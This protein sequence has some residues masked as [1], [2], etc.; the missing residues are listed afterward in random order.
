MNT[1]K[2][3]LAVC[4]LTLVLVIVVLVRQNN[5]REG[6]DNHNSEACMIKEQMIAELSGIEERMRDQSTPI[7]DRDMLS[8][9]K[10]AI[11]SNLRNVLIDCPDN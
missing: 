1:Q 6:Y 11:E 5:S 3:C 8:A 4:T 9:Q 2:L 10:D 7:E